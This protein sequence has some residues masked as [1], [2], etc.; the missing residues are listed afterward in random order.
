MSELE[1]SFVTDLKAQSSITAYVGQRVYEDIAESAAREPYLVVKPV[2]NPRGAFTQTLYGGVARISIYVY[3]ETVA[4]CRA[5]GLLILNR[6]KQFSGT[7][8]AHTVE[9]VEVSNARTL[10]GPGSEFRYLVDLVV[11]YT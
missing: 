7:L 2:D 10:W 5:I 3:A 4:D 9:E 1:T 11:H 6:Y 8:D